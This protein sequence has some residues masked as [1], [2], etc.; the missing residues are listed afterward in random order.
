[1]LPV[2]LG[3]QGTTAKVVTTMDTKMAL[4]TAVNTVMEVMVTGDI[5]TVTIMDMAGT[6]FFCTHFA[7]PLIRRGVSPYLYFK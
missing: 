2:M 1:M 7:C 5:M 4:N 6:K 3:N